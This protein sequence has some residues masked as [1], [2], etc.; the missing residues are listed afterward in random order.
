MMI[1]SPRIYRLDNCSQDWRGSEVWSDY[2]SFSSACPPSQRNTPFC[3]C[4]R[5]VR[6]LYE[7]EVESNIHQLAKLLVQMSADHKFDGTY[8][9][10]TYKW[11]PPNAILFTMTTL[12]MIGLYELWFGVR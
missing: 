9:T 3:A 1:V 4:I 12:T 7:E 2:H 10:F 6:A 8:G 5:M 11:T